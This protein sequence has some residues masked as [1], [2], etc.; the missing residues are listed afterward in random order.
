MIEVDKFLELNKSSLNKGWIAYDK[1]DGWQWFSHKPELL[2][3]DTWS[4]VNGDKMR[5]KIFSILP[6][7]P[8]SSLRRISYV[9]RNMKKVVNPVLQ[10]E[11]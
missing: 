1:K 3:D 4:M 2:L 7:L 10:K 6:I 8:G 11:V 5:L 9:K